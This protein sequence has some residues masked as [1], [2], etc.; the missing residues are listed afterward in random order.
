VNETIVV[1]EPRAEQEGARGR[2]SRIASLL[3]RGSAT[4][5]AVWYA[6]QALLSTLLALR[7]LGFLHRP[8]GIPLVYRSDALSGGSQIKGVLENGWYE[9]NPRLGAPA[10]QNLHDFPIADNL[11]FVFARVFG[12]FTDQWAAVYNLCYLVTFPLTAMAAMWFLRVVGCRRSVAFFFGL[13]YAFTPYHFFHG[14]AHLALSFLFVVPMFGVLLIKV[15]TERPLWVRRAGGSVWNPLTWATLPSLVTLVT[16]ALLGTASSY[17]SVFSLILMTVAVVVVLVRRQFKRAAGA[18][19]TMLALMAV[20]VANMA[21]DILHARAVGPSAA[22]FARQPLESELYAFKLASLLLPVPWHRIT[23]LAEYRADYNAKFPLPS[24]TPALGIVA[25]LGLLF[26]L[27]VPFAATVV[28]SRRLDPEG[29]FGTVQQH[30]SLLGLVSLLFGTVGGFATFFALWVSP[31]IR[32]WNRIVVYLALFALAS[33]ALLVDWALARLASRVRRRRRWRPA[34]EPVVAVAVCGVIAMAGVYDATP[35]TYW[36]A[37]PAVIKAWHN[38]AAYVAKIESRMPAGSAIFE[39]P[40]MQFPESLPIYDMT[41]YELIRPYLHSTDLR[42]SYGGVKGRPASDWQHI[43]AGMPAARMVTIL[44]AAGFSGIHIDRFGF[45]AHRPGQLDDTLK[46]LLGPPVT[47]PNHRFEFYDMR[48]FIDRSRSLYPAATWKELDHHAVASP[49][50]YWQHG[51]SDPGAP[52]DRGGFRLIGSV[53]APYG[54]IDNP[55]DPVTM[56]FSFELH[57][58][59]GRAPKDVAVHW[60]DGSDQTLQVPASGLQLTKEVVVPSGESRLAF[61][62]DASMKSANLFEFSMTDPVLDD[63][64]LRGPAAARFADSCV[65]TRPGEKAPKAA[66][67]KGR[68]PAPG[69]GSTVTQQ[70]VTCPPN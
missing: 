65:T 34:F 30:L 69:A 70:S 44:A 35:P 8:F 25:A 32:A 31:D 29:P 55:G 17:Y 48:D 46:A 3:P 19:V 39:L 61:T 21:P 43:F 37:D 9:Q 10:G 42:W 15:L 50:F 38:D 62:G 22:E 26:L 64:V 14:E 5:S 52:D 60:P 67:K 53:P 68:K 1:D 66:G 6:A 2:M 11:Q 36:N 58:V 56:R 12:L 47:S 13:L 59:G 41:D 16:V 49:A 40:V 27:L 33:L 7:I 54:V 28:R 23:R 18:V 51:F 20:M 24:E 45:R 4:T 63:F 57:A